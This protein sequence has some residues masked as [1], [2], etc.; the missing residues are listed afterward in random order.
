M[1]F[2]AP[3]IGLHVSEKKRV[4][5]LKMAAILIMKRTICLERLINLEDQSRNESWYQ[6][7]QF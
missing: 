1:L 2:W 7:P 6:T 4:N 3:F 5:R